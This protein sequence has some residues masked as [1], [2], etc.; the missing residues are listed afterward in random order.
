MLSGV[1]LPFSAEWLLSNAASSRCSVITAPIESVTVPTNYPG[2]AS[3]YT[4]IPSRYRA[5]LA[6]ARASQSSEVHAGRPD[7]T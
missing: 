4:H 2:S 1:L 3:L 5:T 7:A 6:A